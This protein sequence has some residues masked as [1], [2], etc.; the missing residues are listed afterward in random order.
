[1]ST[2]SWTRKLPSCNVD[3]KLLLE[4]EQYL[5]EKGVELLLDK[6]PEH[7][8]TIIDSGEEVLRNVQDYKFR[9]YSDDT[10]D[11][12]LWLRQ[13]YQYKRDEAIPTVTVT[14]RFKREYSNVR[15]EIDGPKSRELATVML[16]DIKRIIEPHRTVN[17]LFQIHPMAVVL[18]VN[19]ILGLAMMVPK[20]EIKKP[21]LFA[22]GIL[23]C[24]Y[25][26]MTFLKPYTTFHTRRNEKKAKL[27]GYFIAIIVSLV[28]RVLWESLRALFN[29]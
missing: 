24:G 26:G 6:E 5:V 11:L 29:G 12:H 18:F 20:A 13:N 19:L 21:W 15:M 4:L 3:Q 22:A 23:T 9:Y 16:A 27:T 8:F 25:I 2:F 14:I 1:M 17:W 10:Q 7:C 28:G